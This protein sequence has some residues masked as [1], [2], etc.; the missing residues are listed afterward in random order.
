MNTSNVI[1]MLV[2]IIS[3]LLEDEHEIVNTGDVVASIKPS[4]ETCSSPCTVVFSAEDTTSAG[5][6][7]NETWTQLSYY[8]DFDTDES[9]TYGALYPQ[10]YTYVDGDT[11][12]EVGHVPLVTKTFLCEVGTCVYNVGLRAQNRDG[13]YND[14]FQTI[15]VNSESA[16]WTTANTVCVSNSLNI[17]SDWSTFDDPCPIGAIK[18]NTLPLPDEF[19]NKLILLNRGDVFTAT[20]ADNRVGILN[21][22]SNFKVSDFGNSSDD[23]PEIYARVNLDASD[24][25]LTDGV[26]TSIDLRVQHQDPSFGETTNAYFENLRMGA[27]QFPYM[28]QHVG[29]HNIDMDY[30]SD[31]TLVAGRVSWPLGQLCIAFPTFYNCEDFPFPNGAYISSVNL[32]GSQPAYESGA[33]NIVGISCVMTNYIGITDVSAKKAGEHNLRIMGWW[34][35][36]IMRSHFKGQHYQTVKQKLSPRPCVDNLLRDTDA[37]DQTN[38]RNVHWARDIEGRTRADI[39]TND[40]LYYLHKSKYSVTAHNVLGEAGPSQGMNPGGAQFQTHAD[41][42]ADILESIIVA[43]NTFRGCPR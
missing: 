22:Q 35:L 27:F 37:Y 23:P 19:S 10:S 7:A 18:Q 3:Y 13:D 26:V 17:N 2:P 41:D 29:I 6:T 39:V 4:R 28:F 32:V 42:N 12:Y 43:H 5:L 15:T 25:K 14:A 24:Y 16:T 21:G 40:G 20:A 33:V 11:S 8:W 9:D 36:N 1:L 31:T 30:G 34:R 38:Q